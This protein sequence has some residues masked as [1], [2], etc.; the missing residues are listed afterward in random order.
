M[1]GSF[2]LFLMCVGWLVSARDDLL[3]SGVAKQDVYV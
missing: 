2:T 3:K 1:R